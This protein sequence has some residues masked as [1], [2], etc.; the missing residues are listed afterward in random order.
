MISGI[1]NS[2]DPV[3]QKTI[4]TSVSSAQKLLGLNNLFLLALK[5]NSLV[6]LLIQE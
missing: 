2:S 4:F 1:F 5:I 3:D 6:L